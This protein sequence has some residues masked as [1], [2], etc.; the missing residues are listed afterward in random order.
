MS[1]LPPDSDRTADIVGGRAR[2]E[3][4]IHRS[5]QPPCSITSLAHVINIGQ[6]LKLIALAA[7]ALMANSHLVG[8]WTGS[9]DGIL[10]GTS[11][12]NLAPDAS[13]NVGFPETE[14]LLASARYFSCI[15]E[16]ERI[17]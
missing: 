13:S 4:L 7:L 6:S 8:N 14:L 1:G 12:G 3:E 17:S 5:K 9:S 10:T 16:I 2:A 11:V 15:E